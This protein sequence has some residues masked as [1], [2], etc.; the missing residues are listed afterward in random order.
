MDQVSVLISCALCVYGELLCLRARLILYARARMSVHERM[1][2]RACVLVCFCFF[3]CVP[4]S[5]IRLCYVFELM[6]ASATH[7]VPA[8]QYEVLLDQGGLMRFQEMRLLT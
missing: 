7:S 3:L 5:H 4:F 6:R 8:P 1:R 2:A